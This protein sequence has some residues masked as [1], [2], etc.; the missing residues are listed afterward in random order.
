MRT[1]LS[2]DDDVFPLIR[3]YAEGRSLGLGKAVSEL[4]KKGLK[5]PTP[6]RME[7]GFLVFDVPPDSP[8]VTSE[9]IKQLES[10][11]E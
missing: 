8:P 9:R 3:R 5:A 4:V 10:E 2:L 11:L 6:T 7:N 1:T